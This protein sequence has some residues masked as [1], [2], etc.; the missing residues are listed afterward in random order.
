MLLALPI[1]LPLA[2]AI[3]LHLLPQRTRWL[4]VLAFLGALL[5]LAA[6]VSVLVRVLDA[7]DSGPPRRLMAGAVRNHPGSRPL[8]RADGRDDRDYRR[9]RD[10]LIV[11][12]RRFAS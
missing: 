5:L 3:A 11:R 6:G 8:Q 10:G 2:T 9:R 7:G 4:R 1:I 12:R